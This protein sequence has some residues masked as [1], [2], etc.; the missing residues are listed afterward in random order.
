MSS[1]HT[2]SSNLGQPIVYQIRIK[3]H[4]NPLWTDKFENLVMTLED[5]GDTLL[6]G[7]VIDQAALHGLLKRVRDLGMPLLLV[8]C[9]QSGSE[10]IS[11]KQGIKVL[12][13]QK[14][15]Q[16]DASPEEIWAIVGDLSRAPEYTPTIVSAHVDG[17]KRFCTDESG[18]EIHEEMSQ[19]SKELR[20]FAYKHVKSPLPV[21]K[22][23]GWYFVNVKDGLSFFEMHWKLE[24]MDDA[25]E[26]QLTPMLH[27]AVQMT[28]ENVKRLAERGQDA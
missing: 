7:P 13:I 16:I 23:E 25:L 1:K 4:L 22:S 15:I 14:D 9:I 27:S 21:K 5:N 28:L 26:T 18:N 17:M 19:Y 8:K 11:D 2:P 24:F 10:N 6:I 3:G 12:K 20:R